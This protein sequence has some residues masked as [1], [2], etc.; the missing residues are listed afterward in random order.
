M[1][2]GRNIIRWTEST[3]DSSTSRLSGGGLRCRRSRVIVQLLPSPFWRHLKTSATKWPCWSLNP[4][5]FFDTNPV[6][7]ILNRFS[8]E[9][10]FMDNLLPP[11]FLYDSIACLS[12]RHNNPRYRELL[13]LAASSSYFCSITPPRITPSKSSRKLKK[14]E[15]IK[16]SPLH[17][18][19][20]ETIT[21][22]K[23]CTLCKHEQNV[24]E[25]GSH[26]GIASK[27][28]SCAYR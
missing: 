28:E 10:G 17:T 27:D 2:N 19:I 7:P 5:L 24:S 1:G 23:E 25:N 8:K 14:I 22:L 13:A 15:A 20:T 4:L 11:T 18:H 26:Q 9:V 3:D 12:T 21:F 6:R 16:R